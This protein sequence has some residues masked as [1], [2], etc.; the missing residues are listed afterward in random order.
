MALGILTFE[1]QPPYCEEARCRKRPQL[2]SVHSSINHKHRSEQAPSLQV[3]HWRP[4][5]W[6]GR[7]MLTMLYCPDSWPTESMSTASGCFPLRFGGLCD[8]VM[9]MGT[10]FLCDSQLSADAQQWLPRWTCL[11]VWHLGISFSCFRAQPPIHKLPYYIYPTL[12]I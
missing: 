2:R 5:T 10:V 3:L 11:H 4:Q 8:A 12:E 6:G 7:A 9:V 1:L